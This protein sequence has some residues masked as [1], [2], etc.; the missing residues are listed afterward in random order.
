MLNINISHVS[1]MQARAKE[2]IRWREDKLQEKKMEE[3]RVVIE[4]KAKAHDAHYKQVRMGNLDRG[5][6]RVKI[7]RSEE[8]T[9]EEV[10]TRSGPELNIL[11]RGT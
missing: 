3:D 1:N 2:V 4:E 9:S 10:K 7:Y 11:I 6:Y 8:R 5:R